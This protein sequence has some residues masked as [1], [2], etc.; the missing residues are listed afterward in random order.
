MSNLWYNTAMTK[1]KQERSLCIG[2]MACVGLAPEKFEVADDGLAQIKS[3]AQVAEGTVEVDDT[4]APT[5]VSACCGGAL[6]EAV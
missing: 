2:C 3:D 6:S 1:I 4:L 5:L